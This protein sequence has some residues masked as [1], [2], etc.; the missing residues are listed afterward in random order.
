TWTWIT[1]ALLAA[2][3]L[4]SVGRG[5]CGT[6]WCS[7]GL[8]P[9]LPNPLPCSMQG[10]PLAGECFA[11]RWVAA[12]SAFICKHIAAQNGLSWK[13]PLKAPWFNSPAVRR[14]THSSISA[15]SPSPDL[16]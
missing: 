11:F 14:G 8:V 13:R 7:P 6:S 2:L 1:L 12:T 4:L 10:L 9:V 5:C 3:L 15:Q 16:G